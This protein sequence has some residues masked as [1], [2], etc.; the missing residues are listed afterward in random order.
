MPL[1]ALSFRTAVENL[2]QLLVVQNGARL[3]FES[4]PIFRTVVCR[5]VDEWEGTLPDDQALDAV[6]LEPAEVLIECAFLDGP[7]FACGIV[8]E[9]ANQVVDLIGQVGDG[10]IG[11]SRADGES[12]FPFGSAEIVIRPSSDNAIRIPLKASETPLPRG[13]PSADA[14]KERASSGMSGA[15][16]MGHDRSP[17]A[18]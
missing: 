8:P 2:I 1:V 6:R 5:I 15:S 16:R 7:P 9:N 3:F 17:P 11:R 13:L 10:A 18:T 14:V 12:L 4:I